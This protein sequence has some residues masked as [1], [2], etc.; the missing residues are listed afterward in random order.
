MERQPRPRH[1]DGDWRAGARPTP[2][3]RRPGRAKARSPATRRS[4]N[5]A[6]A[7]RTGR[8]CTEP[9]RSRR[10]DQ[11]RCVRMNK[12]TRVDAL[13]AVPSRSATTSA[14]RTWISSSLPA[15]SR[16]RTASTS[17]S[18]APASRTLPPGSVGDIQA[19]EVPNT[20]SA[21]TS[22]S[23]SLASG[24]RRAFLNAAGNPTESGRHGR[25]KSA[26]EAINA[27]LVGKVFRHDDPEH[28]RAAGQ[29]GRFY[30]VVFDGQLG[31]HPDDDVCA[32]RHT[33]A[34]WAACTGQARRNG[35]CPH[36]QC[37]GTGKRPTSTWPPAPS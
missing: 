9:E 5:T 13:A 22:R 35:E 27:A 33:G 24:R 36:A 28:R 12:P 7:R 32:D 26:I 6:W 34:A 2:Y 31:E 20:N 17:R 15:S 21:G 19:I 37:R 16:F 10:G 1:R 4:T 29:A 18:T 8:I 11:R 30:L 25:A 23:P 3:P 14:A